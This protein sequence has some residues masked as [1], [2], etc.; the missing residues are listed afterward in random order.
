MTETEEETL[1]EEEV[2]ISDALT[3]RLVVFNDDVNSFGHVIYCFM[4]ILHMSQ[5]QAEQ[6]AMIIHERG[7][8]IVK[9]GSRDDLKPYCEALVEEAIDARI[10]D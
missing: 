7:K 5:T 1:L 6:C 8:Y 2:D 3:P 4:I 10:I 9:N